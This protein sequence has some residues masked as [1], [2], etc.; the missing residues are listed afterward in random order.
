M[1]VYNKTINGY[2]CSITV[3]GAD[4]SAAVAGEIC[5]NAT[6]TA[7][8]VPGDVLRDAKAAIVE[9]AG[10]FAD[11][12]VVKDRGAEARAEAMLAGQGWVKV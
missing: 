10:L 3:N 4:V 8:Y 6:A 11:Q 12:E 5:F 1:P 2:V 9:L 7:E